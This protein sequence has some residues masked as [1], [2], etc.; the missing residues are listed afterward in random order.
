V[1]GVDFSRVALAKA[2]TKARAA[3]TAVRFVY[4]D[5]TALR[6]ELG[7]FDFLVDYGTLDDLAP[8]DRDRY[9]DNVVPLAAPGARFLLWCFSW[10]VRRVDR[11]LRFQPIAPGEVEQRFGARFTVERIDGMEVPRMRQLI[12]GSAAY[13]MTRKATT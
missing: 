5:L 2:A 10:P 11:W 3:G 7:A 8:A 1:T 4:D 9:V 13:L 12:P 6:H